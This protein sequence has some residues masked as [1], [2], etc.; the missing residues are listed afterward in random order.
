[1]A[2]DQHHNHL[3]LV[4]LSCTGKRESNTKLESFAQALATS[5]DSIGQARPQSGF[6][7]VAVGR[8]VTGGWQKNL[9]AAAATKATDQFGRRLRASGVAFV[10]AQPHQKRLPSGSGGPLLLVERVHCHDTRPG[11]PNQ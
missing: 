11:M 2:P 3:Q 10:K 1:M 7:R 5:E 9:Q 4:C 6:M 8:A